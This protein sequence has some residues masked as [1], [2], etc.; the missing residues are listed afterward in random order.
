MEMKL[1][2]MRVKA[3]IAACAMLLKAVIVLCAM[4]I[5]VALSSCTLMKKAA[6]DTTAAGNDAVVPV[7]NGFIKNADINQKLQNE[8][9]PAAEQLKSVTEDSEGR[10][11]VEYKMTEVNGGLFHPVYRITMSLSDESDSMVLKTVEISGFDTVRATDANDIAWLHSAEIAES[12][13]DLQRLGIEVDTAQLGENSTELNTVE[14]FLKVYEGLAGKEIDVSDV[15]VGSDDLMKK[16]YLMSLIDYV[17]DVDY[18]F[19]ENANLYRTT[20]LIAQ[21]L[22]NIERDVYGRQSET[23]TGEEFAS[24]LRFLYSVMRVK[25]VEGSEKKWSELATVDTDAI[26]E[27]MEMTG[28]PFTRRDAAE[29][30]GRI[31]KTGPKF[32][33]KYNDHNLQR[34]EDAYDSIWVRRAVTHGFMNYYGDSTLFAPAEGL[35]LV[36][37]ISSAKCYL[38]ARYN[39]WAYSVNYEWDG[40]YTNED[41]IIS[42]AKLAEYFSDRTDSDRDFQVKTV[43]CQLYAFHSDDGSP[44]A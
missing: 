19:D 44:L 37:A 31:T 39:D 26:L 30:V 12:V 25:D 33:L 4:L 40:N 36:N 20:E 29:F 8:F 21:M 41:V 9:L 28:K 15:T 23:V 10:L 5:S 38:N 35:T 14:V 42:A 16:A 13:F 18:Q 17:T 34:V 22:T 7:V 32:A 24:L 1:N 6:M 3:V 43:G 11:H 27:T 2:G